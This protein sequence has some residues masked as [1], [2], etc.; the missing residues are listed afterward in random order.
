[1]E[2]SSSFESFDGLR[3]DG[4][5]KDYFV[6][7]AKW[8]KFIGVVGFVMTGFLVIGSLGMLAIGARVGGLPGVPISP[9]LFGIIYLGVSVILF[10]NSWYLFNFG[11][12]MVR[13]GENN[14]KEDFKQAAKNLR[15]WFRLTGILLLISLSFYALAFLIGL[16]VI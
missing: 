3:A 16:M 2:N 12:K 13:A 1:M 4:V 11:T 7:S 5:I 10:F 9:A 14:S 8:S 15:S 6:Q